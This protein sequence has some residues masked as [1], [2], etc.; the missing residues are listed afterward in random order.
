M[1]LEWHAQLNRRTRID[2]GHQGATF[3]V[4]LWWL[5]QRKDLDDSVY[6]FWVYFQSERLTQQHPPIVKYNSSPRAERHHGYSL[7]LWSIYSWFIP[8]LKDL[9]VEVMSCCLLVIDSLVLFN[10]RFIR[11]LAFLPIAELDRRWLCCSFMYFKCTV[12]PAVN[13]LLI[14]IIQH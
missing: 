10:M 8:V 11:T 14:N 5:Q 4:L 6:C 13:E 12:K 2:S 1:W 3:A 9:T 7:V